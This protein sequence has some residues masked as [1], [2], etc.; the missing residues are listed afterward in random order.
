MSKK[1]G[2]HAA[3][4]P[5]SEAGKLRVRIEEL[6]R[7]LKEQQV[8]QQKL[9]AIATKAAV[10]AESSGGKGGATMD[11]SMRQ[12]VVP[13]ELL[14]LLSIPYEEQLLAACSVAGALL[15]LIVSKGL[16]QRGWLG[17][18][19]GLVW[20][21]NNYDKPGRVS[22][23][24]RATGRLF[25]L[26]FYQWRYLVE[27]LKMKFRA[28]KVYE[29]AFKRFEDLDK[30]HKMLDKLQAF[31][32]RHQIS[33][34]VQTTWKKL[35]DGTVQKDA[36][37]ALAHSATQAQASWRTFSKEAAKRWDEFIE[38]HSR[39]QKPNTSATTTAAAAAAA[40]TT[41][42]AADAHTGSLVAPI[43][44]QKPPTTERPNGHQPQDEKRGASAARVAVGEPVASAT[45]TDRGVTE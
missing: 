35:A 4:E 16:L 28:W 19:I 26:A 21:I 45:Q 24:V 39:A 14:Q 31:D 32:E 40:N 12:R 15:G 3:S 38:S 20:A 33:Q 7:Q 18:A 1:G 43:D 30:Q 41:V 27:D 42:P 8:Q 22:R 6:E 25:V 13:P 23:W 9:L 36:R 11:S 37:T 10:A 29:R 5:E 34:N 17:A 44:Q 2:R